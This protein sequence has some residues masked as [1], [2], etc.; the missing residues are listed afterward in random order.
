[1]SEQCLEEKIV[2]FFSGDTIVMDAE[3]E[4]ISS[5]SGTRLTRSYTGVSESDLCY[6]IYT[7]GTTG[8]PKGVMTEH[9]N[10]YRF[11]NAFNEICGTTTSDRIYQGFS[12]GFDGSVE[13]IWMA[14]SNGSALVVG[15]P[16]T[17]RFGNDLAQFLTASG[18]TYF[19]TVPT[20]LSTI[21]DEV[22]TLRQLVVSG[23]A[24][25]P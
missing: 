12:L 18:V 15:T 5:M 11:V 14:F 9:R 17:P 16:E 23:E 8:R 25:P 7:S 24:C 20:M 4:E 2:G 21:T 13:E 10:A 1:M 19:S 22:P 3:A 6:I